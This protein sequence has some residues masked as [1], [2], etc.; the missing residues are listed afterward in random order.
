MRP[1]K[2]RSLSVGSQLGSVK[3]CCGARIL[4]YA[5]YSWCQNLRKDFSDFRL[6]SFLDGNVSTQLRG[7]LFLLR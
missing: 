5:V 6:I 7:F 1:G 3:L 4:V 2:L